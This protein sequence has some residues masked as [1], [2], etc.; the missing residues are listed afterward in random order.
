MC[1]ALTQGIR[2]I[3]SFVKY[4]SATGDMIYLSQKT[5]VRAVSNVEITMT[6]QKQLVKLKVP[7]INY[8]Y[9]AKKFELLLQS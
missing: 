9:F 1:H 7:S 4:K 3:K 8:P 2:T 5:Q 6:K